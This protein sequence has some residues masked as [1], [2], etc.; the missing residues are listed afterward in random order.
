MTLNDIDKIY[1]LHLSDRFDRKEWLNNQIQFVEFPE[2]KVNI[3]WTCRRNFFNDNKQLIDIEENIYDHKNEDKLNIS[4]I[5]G[6]F[7]CALEHY[8][9]I[10]TSYDRGYNN[11]LIFEDDVNF[12]VKSD[13]FN[14]F[15]QYVPENYKCIK[16]YNRN[17]TNEFVSKDYST[18]YFNIPTNDNINNPYSKYIIETHN[19]Y[20]EILR[21]TTA[22]MLDRQGMKELIKIYDK[23]FPLPCDIFFNYLDYVYLCNYKLVTTQDLVSNEFNYLLSDLWDIDTNQIYSNI[24]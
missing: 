19:H 8:T 3:W 9:I 13:M 14:I 21:S 2:D 4:R 15:L 22:Y 18:H 10:R 24:I 12:F 17:Q 16:F 20:N 11:I 6:I 1:F 23:Y 5:S 7:N